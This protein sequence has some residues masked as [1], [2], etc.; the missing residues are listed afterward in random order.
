MMPIQLNTDNL[1]R[2]APAVHVPVY[3]RGKIKSGIVHIGIGGFHRAHQAYCID[4]LLE[5]GLAADWGICGISLLVPDRKIHDVLAK[6]EG[7]YTLMIPDAT[8]N[9]SARVIGSVTELLYA[10]ENPSAAIQKMADKSIRLITLTITEGGYNFTSDGVFNWHNDAVLWDLNYPSQPKTV[11]GY[12]YAALKLRRDQGIG[13]LTIQSCDN[14]EHNG[15]IMRSMLYAFIS[16]ADP[17][18]ISWLDTY[19]TFPNSMVDRITPVTTDSLKTAV[20]EN[21][22]LHD[23]WP[24]ICEPFYQWII[25]DNYAAGRPEWEKAGGQLVPDVTPYEKMKIRLLN[26]GHTLVGLAGYLSGY[27]YIHESIADPAIAALLHK[28]MNEEVT[29]ALDSVEGIDLDEYKNTL[30]ERFK[31]PFIKDEVTRIISGSSGK[32]PKFILPVILDQ[33]QENR[34]VQIAALIV[35]CW[36]QYLKMNIPDPVDVQDEMASI[37]LKNITE[38]EQTQNPA[39][40]LNL[41]EVFGNLR[42]KRMFV[43]SFISHITALNS[44]KI[45]SLIE[46]E[47]NNV[48]N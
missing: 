30:I 3:N 18:M 40:F 39:H 23:G 37:L 14:I 47:V 22:G 17:A 26:G 33:L 15:D 4:R 8:G 13:G 28:Y 46:A 27:R 12:L 42:E 21:F 34:P 25:E 2:L 9:F 6:Q 1:T 48:V 32:F 31:N 16:K 38:A 11:F 19:I 5:Q 10:P 24:V 35:A 29:P 7:L 36:Y 41:T 43:K 45:R 20:A 44:N